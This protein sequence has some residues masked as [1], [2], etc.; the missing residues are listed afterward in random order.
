MSVKERVIGMLKSQ[1]EFEEEVAR[2][3]QLLSTLQAARPH[4]A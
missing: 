1:Q 2:N 4:D 3:S